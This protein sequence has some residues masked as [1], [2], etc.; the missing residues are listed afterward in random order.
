MV[1]YAKVA[2]PCNVQSSS[3]S[4]SLFFHKIVP[5]MFSVLRYFVKYS[6]LYLGESDFFRVWIFADVCLKEEFRSTSAM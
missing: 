6:C 2:R 5:Q 4:L 1:L 3:T